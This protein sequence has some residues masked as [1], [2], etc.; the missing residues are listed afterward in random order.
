MMVK[1]TDQLEIASQ[2]TD[3][4]HPVNSVH[5]LD[6][7]STGVG[8]QLCSSRKVLALPRSQFIRDIVTGYKVFVMDVHLSL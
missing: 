7:P 2:P 1:R 8:G 3:P 5:I 6:A 4:K